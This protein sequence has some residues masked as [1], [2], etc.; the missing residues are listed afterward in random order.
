MSLERIVVVGKPGSGK[1]TLAKELARKLELAYVELDAIHW[2]PNWAMLPKHEMRERLNETLVVD[3][4]W[5]ADGNYTRRA[6]DIVWGRANTLIWLDYPLRVAL[7]RLL[8][9]TILRLFWRQELWNGNK[10]TLWSHLSLDPDKNL[11]IWLFRLHWRHREEFPALF[12]QPEYS[13]L[14][15]LRFRTPTET[16]QWLDGL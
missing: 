13:H 15:V 6:I 3:G 7:I 2:Q 12:R 8:W 9:R 1:S 11:F 16:E 10:E 14:K 4:H 5:V